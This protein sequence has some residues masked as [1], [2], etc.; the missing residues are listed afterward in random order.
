M[1]LIMFGIMYFLVIRPQSKKQKEHQDFLS[2][3]KSGDQVIT[4]GGLL[5]E[6][7]NVEEATVTVKLDDKV[8]V[9]VVRSHI[10]GL[11]SSTAEDKK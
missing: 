5:G 2:R 6:I 3:L 9:K 10:L 4:Q 11:Q 1:M 8:R 7:V